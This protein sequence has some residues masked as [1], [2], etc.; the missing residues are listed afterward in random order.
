MHNALFPV[1]FGLWH[2]GGE[3]AATVAPLDLAERLSRLADTSGDPAQRLVADYAFSHNYFWL[4]RYADARRHQ[5]AAI[6]NPRA[7]GSAALIAL[8]GED[9]I[10][11]S[12]SFLAWTL[13]F[14]GYPARAQALMEETVAAARAADHTHTL[15][16][17]LIF[18]G[19]LSRHLVQP[20]TTLAYAREVTELADR[21]SLSLWQAAANALTG[22]ALGMQGDPSGITYMRRGIDL[23]RGAMHLIESTFRSYLVEVLAHQGQHSAVIT[24]AEGAI[25]VAQACN[26]PYLLPEFHRLKAAAILATTPAQASTARAELETALRLACSQGNHW[27][28]LRILTDLQRLPQST[29]AER[30]QWQGQLERIRQDILDEAPT[31][32]ELFDLKRSQSVRQ[33]TARSDQRKSQA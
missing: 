8:C 4:G 19:V 11:L 16:Y 17:V 22:W 32:A 27:F 30:R 24:E 15:C 29:A 31:N 9:S 20:E 12:A 2:G 1:L 14:Q 13:C 25:A 6:R 28:E 23:C 26:D 33:N 21:H 5:E 10:L 3:N 18:A 7:I